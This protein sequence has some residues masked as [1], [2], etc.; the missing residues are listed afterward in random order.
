MTIRL[1]D[2][3][4]R[5]GEQREGVSLTVEDK[6]RIAAR[7][8]TLGIHYI[9]GGF[10]ASNATDSSFYEQLKGH[11]LHHAEISAFGMTARKGVSPSDDEGVRALIKCSADLITIVGKASETHAQKVLGVTSE[12]NLRMIKDTIAYLV[13]AE[14]R[15]FFDAEHYF[16]AYRENPEYALK[17]IVVAHD[18]G[19]EALI[20]CDTNGGAL[21]HEVF[22]V[23]SK[24][25]SEL[26]ARC[27]STVIGIHAHNDSGCGVANSLEAVRAGAT[28]VQGTVNGYGERVGNADLLAILANLQIKLGY[29]IVTGSQLAQLASVSRFVSETFNVYHDA[30]LPYVGQNAFSHKGGIHAG[31]TARLKHAYEHI[32][33]A[34]VGNFAHIVVSELAG[35]ASLVTKAAELGVKLPDDNTKIKQL[36]DTVKFRESQGYSY[37]VADAS[38]SLLLR[39]EL[40]QD[41]AC[42]TLESFRVIAEKREDGKVMSEATIKLMVGNERYVATGEGNGPVNALDAALRLAIQRYYPRVDS[43]ELTD[44]KVRV[45][46]AGAGTGAV[47]RVLIETSDGTTSWGTIGVS[48]NIIEA[49]WD[50]LVDAITYG[51]ILGPE[52]EQ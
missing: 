32:N 13:A 25:I 52:E 29:Q 12:D 28:Q 46:D 7:L 41:T 34:L 4:L 42:F 51:L 17:T 22:C 36:L 15:V 30:H 37:E 50:A 47:T 5:D 9:E 6:L 44:Y 31:A 40:G 21:P 48:E 24:T 39:G 1:Y 26:S 10:P 2:T 27:I 43:F 38:L 3:T 18:A 33:P 8:D 19:A 20:L 11:R 16:D 49:S 45:L 23:T 14:K 35:K